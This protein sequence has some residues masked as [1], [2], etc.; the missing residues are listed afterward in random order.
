MK[1]T[2][3]QYLEI[4]TSPMRVMSLGIRLYIVTCCTDINRDV[5]HDSTLNVCCFIFANRYIQ[6]LFNFRQET[7]PCFF[8]GCVERIKDDCLVTYQ[9]NDPSTS[10]TVLNSV[11]TISLFRVAC[12][13][14][15]CSKPTHVTSG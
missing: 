1:L 5:I 13:K 4:M 8:V 6:T 3:V 9:C 11:L 12:C 10:M 2:V 14:V 7:I 15:N